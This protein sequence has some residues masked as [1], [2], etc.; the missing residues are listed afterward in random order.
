V[1]VCIVLI[2]LSQFIL[3][4]ASKKFSYPQSFLVI[5]KCVESTRT[6]L[7]NLY[8]NQVKLYNF[9]KSY[10][11]YLTLAYRSV[12]INKQKHAWASAVKYRHSPATVKSENQH[13]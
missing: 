6:K 1:Q 3:G 5:H 10:I 11:T 4:R 7:H 13:V 9:I 2:L 8:L 12:T